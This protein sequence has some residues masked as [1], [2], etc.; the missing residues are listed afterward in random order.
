MNHRDIAS[1]LYSLILKGFQAENPYT[2]ETGKVTVMGAYADAVI[3]ELQ[4][5]HYVI[6]VEKYNYG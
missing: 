2:G 3:V 6:K 4:G 5:E 1:A